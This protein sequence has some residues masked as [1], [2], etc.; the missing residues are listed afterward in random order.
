MST[1]VNVSFARSE[2][3]SDLMAFAVG[4]GNNFSA[5]G[6]DIFAQI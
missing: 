3:T 1:A 4:S 5:R 6:T 2:V